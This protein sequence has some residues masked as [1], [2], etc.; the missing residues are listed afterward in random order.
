MSYW[1]YEIVTEDIAG[2]VGIR[3]THHLRLTFNDTKTAM[4]YEGSYTVDGVG[5]ASATLYAWSL[6]V[7]VNGGAP[8]IKDFSNSN[9]TPNYFFASTVPIS[10]NA[11]A[12]TNISIATSATGRGNSGIYNT[13]FSN[14]YYYTLLPN[15]FSDCLVMSYNDNY[16]M[17]LEPASY[18]S[19][20]SNV[21]FIKYLGSG[22]L[23][24]LPST[25]CALDT[26]TVGSEYQVYGQNTGLVLFR[27]SQT[28]WKI[29][30]TYRNDIQTSPTLPSP[31]PTGSKSVTAGAGKVNIFRVDDVTKS[32]SDNLCYLPSPSS[33]PGK[34]CIVVYGGPLGK[35]K[36]S[37]GNASNVLYFDVVGGG[38]NS[39]IDTP[40]GGY[41]FLFT[42]GPDKSTG[43]IFIS[44][45][46]KWCIMGWNQ[47]FGQT[48]DKNV[49]AGAPRTPIPANVNIFNFNNR[50]GNM[51]YQMPAYNPALVNASSLIICKSNGDTSPEGAVFHAEGVS[52]RFNDDI[53]RIF[54]DGYPYSCMIFVTYID[55]TNSRT[56]YYPISS[57]IPS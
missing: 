5:G 32:T 4:N 11:G 13:T 22:Y 26:K 7:Y 36:F 20:F 55:T 30:N 47:T 40:D 28:A 49:D 8:V 34:M 2:G 16:L 21:K 15:N 19:G 29:A 1:L 3:L 38:G 33:A 57:Y 23:I 18:A 35:N 6:T 12:V 24:I 52:N 9:D 54:L 39:I 27:S 46:S 14:N 53:Y 25:S 51:H 45:G 10:V 17:S 42:D 37:P 50:T 31:L 41:P 44:S 43:V 56:C 48:W